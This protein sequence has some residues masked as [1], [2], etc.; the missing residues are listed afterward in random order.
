MHVQ[1]MENG[2]VICCELTSHI[3]SQHGNHFRN[4]TRKKV[5]QMIETVIAFLLLFLGVIC[6]EPLLVLSS[7]FYAIAVNIGNLVEA[8]KK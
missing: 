3:G 7:S 4:H 1:Q 6:E 2:V 8:V 5:E